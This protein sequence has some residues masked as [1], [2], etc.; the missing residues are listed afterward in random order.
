MRLQGSEL[1]LSD[2][3]GKLCTF[4]AADNL[5]E[6]QRLIQNGIDCNSGACYT[7]YAHIALW[8]IRSTRVR[9][10]VGGGHIHMHT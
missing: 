1:K 5:Y 9:V 7:T 10:I 4:A 3:A 2:A 6:L 8:Y